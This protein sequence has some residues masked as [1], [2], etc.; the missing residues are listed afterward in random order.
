MQFATSLVP[1]TTGDPLSASEPRKKGKTQRRQGPL[2]DFSRLLIEWMIRRRKGE[3]WN[4]TE[5]ATESG[6]N[7][8]SIVHMENG[9]QSMSTENLMAL[10][11]TFNKL[12]LRMLLNE[13]KALYDGLD[14]RGELP[15]PPLGA[16]PKS[17]GYE[18]VDPDGSLVKKSPAQRRPSSSAGTKSRSSET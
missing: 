5:L 6:I 12:S 17:T 1:W 7:R 3:G 18:A 9:R 14:E 2:D 11:K 4:Q 10:A 16:K 15:L 13:V 8:I